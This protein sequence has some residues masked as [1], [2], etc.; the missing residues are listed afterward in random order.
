MR[1]YASKTVRPRLAHACRDRRRGHRLRRRLG[2]LRDR[3]GCYR[4]VRMILR[5]PKAPPADA[6]VKDRKTYEQ[7]VR[8]LWR[9]LLLSVKAKL[10]AVQSGIATFD[11]EWLS[12]VV[13]PNDEA[14][15]DRILPQLTTGF[16]NNEAPKLLLS[17]RS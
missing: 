1:R 15:G 2:G 4:S 8:R 6:M 5:L 10:E 16:K 14:I 9:A 13:M 3:D 17:F 7:E 12:Y 11:Q